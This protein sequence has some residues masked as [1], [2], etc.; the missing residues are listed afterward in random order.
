MTT[1]A[2]T[3]NALTKTYAGATLPVIK[4]VSFSVA[5][6]KIVVLMG[7]SG[8]GKTHVPNNQC[9]LFTAGRGQPPSA[10]SVAAFIDTVSGILH[11]QGVVES[12][13][14]LRFKSD[15]PR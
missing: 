8:A 10:S 7:R 13:L 11:Q 4:D 2:L 1:H 9:A 3:V 15:L 14:R 12:A 6:G 5:R